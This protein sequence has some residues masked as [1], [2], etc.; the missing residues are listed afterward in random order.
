MLLKGKKTM[1]RADVHLVL[2]EKKDYIHFF[3]LLFLSY[4][5]SAL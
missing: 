2:A 1:C 4:Y 5:L 3:L